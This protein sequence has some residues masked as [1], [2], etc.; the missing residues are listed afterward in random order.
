MLE[1]MALR[2]ILA[3]ASPRRRLL[4]EMAGVR[5]EVWQGAPD[6][7]LPEDT[8]AASWGLMAARKKAEWFRSKRPSGSVLVTADTTVV[9]DNE[10]LNKPHD[11]E[12][13]FHMLQRLNGR[14]HQVMTGVCVLTD[15]GE[16][17][18]VETTEVTFRQ[19]PEAFLRA[20][21]QSGQGLDKAGSYGAQDAF[22]IL[23]IQAI[24]GCF[25]NVMGLPVSRIFFELGQ[26]FKS[27]LSITK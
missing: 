18:F 9:L 26:L 27:S 4:L 13:A 3:S 16:V 2:W 8:P 23:G 22:G 17:A 7:N 14:T 12:D 10:V 6:E 1:L 5:P 20:Y 19:L 15:A 24:H 25:Y 11:A 21:A